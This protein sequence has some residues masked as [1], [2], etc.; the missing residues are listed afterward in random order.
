M[1]R[2]K[3]VT[4]QRQ[5]MWI[6]IGLAI[7]VLPTINGKQYPFITF[8]HQ[9]P[10]NEAPPHTKLELTL[11]LSARNLIELRPMSDA[12]PNVFINFACAVHTSSDHSPT[13]RRSHA[14]TVLRIFFHLNI[15]FFRQF[16]FTVL[17]CFSHQTFPTALSCMCEER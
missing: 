6:V 12:F 10:I 5:V 13:V 14:F 3:R 17:N 7:A 9:N 15:F 16:V 4:M 11:L 8:G 2:D 1:A